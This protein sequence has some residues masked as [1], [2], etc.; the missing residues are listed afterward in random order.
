[1]TKEEFIILLNKYIEGTASTKDIQLFNRFYQKMVSEPSS[2]WSFSE[3]EQMQLEVLA[4]LNKIIDDHSNSSQ[5]SNKQ[6]KWR[7][8]MAA[9]VVIVALLSLSSYYLFFNTLKPS[10]ITVKTK[11][12]QTLNITLDDGSTIQLNAKSAI[13]YPKRFGDKERIVSLSGEAFFNVARN[14][15]KPFIINT[16]NISTTVLGTS[17]NIEAYKTQKDIKVSVA[18]GKV[19]VSKIKSIDEPSELDKTSQKSSI[20][21]RPNE[22][23]VFNR[24]TNQLTKSEANAENFLAWQNG[25][26]YL[27]N[28]SLKEVVATLSRWYNTEIIL[29]NDSLSKC[30]ISGKYKRDNLN[31]LLKSLKFMQAIDYEYVNEHK[32]ILSG[33][34]CN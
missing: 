24:G 12:G 6:V 22:Q 14:A 28:T 13:T 11:T 10:F 29:K 31:N 15:K 7:Y 25:V 20:I 30:Q 33:K 16:Q 1:M 8:W 26:F 21:L 19:K 4:N 17:F 34:T 5:N 27:D 23:A 18:S 32:V 9:S 2:D 3:K